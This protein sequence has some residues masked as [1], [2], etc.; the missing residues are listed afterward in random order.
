MNRVYNTTKGKG[1]D[2]ILF[3]HGLWGGGNYLRGITLVPDTYTQYYPDQLGFGKSPKPNITYTPKLH[4]QVIEHILP[5]NTQVTLI[6]HSFGGTLAINFASLYPS[7]I[8]KIILISP[9]IYKNKPDAI[10][11][12]STNFITKLTI[13]HPSVAH[14]ICNSVCSTGVLGKVSPFFVSKN[15]KGYIGGCTEHTWD[16]YYS[17]FINGIINNP[18]AELTNELAK[19][20]PVCIIYGDSDNYINY[21]VLNKLHIKKILIPH[22]DHFA[23]FE[24]LDKCKKNIAEYLEDK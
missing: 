13:K 22:S 8:K 9:L 20:I 14:I 2:S 10:K 7:R 23:L 18:I 11:H 16:S 1:G 24:H 17:T 21:E 19:K 4:S 6:G 12:L 15:R 3:F 5:K